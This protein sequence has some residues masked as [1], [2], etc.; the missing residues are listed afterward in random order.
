MGRYD[1]PKKKITVRSE[2]FSL[3]PRRGG[4]M[5]FWI[6]VGKRVRKQGVRHSDR[7]QIATICAQ[8]D[9]NMRAKGR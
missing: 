3:Y 8:V 6:S 5:G 7:T 9:A 1:P 4:D 2:W